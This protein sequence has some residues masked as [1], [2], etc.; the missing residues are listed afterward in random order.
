MVVDD[1]MTLH[2]GIIKMTAHWDIFFFFA[3]VHSAKRQAHSCPIRSVSLP[4]ATIGTKFPPFKS[5]A[6]ITKLF[7]AAIIFVT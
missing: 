2:L 5:W 4:Q 6:Y 1:K 3:L 7:T